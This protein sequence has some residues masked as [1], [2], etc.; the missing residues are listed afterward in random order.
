[1]KKLSWSSKLN[2]DIIRGFTLDIIINQ[3]GKPKKIPLKIGTIGNE[4]RIPCYDCVSDTC[5]FEEYNEE[6]Y[7]L[8]KDAENQISC[9][10][11]FGNGFKCYCNDDGQCGWD[12]VTY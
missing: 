9:N 10:T 6:L 3:G 12:D 8:I 11:K 5:G 2:G 7:Y 1:V 4:L